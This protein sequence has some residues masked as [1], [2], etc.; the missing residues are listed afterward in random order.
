[1]KKKIIRYVYF[2]LFS[3]F[4][5][6][7]M[8]AE[9]SENMQTGNGIAEE[10]KIIRVGYY[11]DSESFQS[12]SGDNT[13]K[14]GY[15]Y[16]YYQ[17]IAKYTGWTYEYV[18]GSWSE[19]YEKL[20]NGE[21]DIM[22]GISKIEGRESQMLFSDYAMGKESYYIYALAGSNIIPHDAA[23]LDGARI[24]VKSNSHMHQ[25]LTEFT[26]SKGID[27][28][29]IPYAGLPERLTALE[30]NELDCIVTVENGMTPDLL[31]VY[32]LGSSDFYFAVSKDRPDILAELNTAQS[33]IM[34]IFPYYVLQLQNQYFGQNTISQELTLK[35]QEWL[36]SHQELKVGYLT[37]YMPY[38]GS[39]KDYG[40]LT[41][42]LPEL[43][44][45]F[46]EYTGSQFTPI[47]FD[48]YE[49]MLQALGNGELDMI[50]PTFQD[51]WYS[52]HQ[53][54]TQTVSVITTRMTV[55]Y[56]GDY[57][58]G[59]YDRIA[60]SDGSPLQP[61]YLTINYPDAEQASYDNWSE[62]LAA[63]QSGEVGCMLINSNL[64]YRYLS[65][66]EE[67]ADLHVAEL[68]DTIGF[69]FAVRRGNSILYSILNKGLNNIDATSINDAVI[70]NSYVEPE[71]TFRQFLFNN[72]GLVFTIV[73]VFV[74]LLILFFLLYW[75]RIKRERRILEEN[76]EK[77]KKYIADKEEKFNIIG[78]L[79]RIYAHTYYIN[80]KDNVYQLI[81][82]MDLKKDNLRY[83]DTSKSRVHSLIDMS[84]KE[85]DRERLQSFLDL[86]TLSDRMESVD[87]ISME[88]ETENRGWFRGN[89]IS[90]ERNPQGRLQYVIYAIQEINDEKSAQLQAQMALK[91]A[92]EA[93]NR[94]NHA[95]SDF[96]ARMSHDIRTPMN[97]IIGMTAIATTHIDEKGRVEDCLKKI[98]ASGKHL[99][100][101]IN[102]VLDMSKIESGRLE[103]SEEE[104]NIED[105]ID[106]ML[107]VIQPQVD[108][109]KHTLRVSVGD[110]EHEEVIGDSLHIQ[111]VFINILSNSVKYT[112][113]G[114]ILSLTVTE[115]PV[116]KP[117]IGCYEF[118]FE[119]N[120][121]G[122][123]KEFMEHIFEPFSRENETSSNKVQGTGLGLSIVANI[124]RMMG[125]DIKVE[126]VQGEGSKFTVT[127]F[128]KLQD[129][130]DVSFEDSV[131]IPVLVVDDQQDACE[132]TC[133]LLKELGIKSEWVLSG[134]EALEKLQAS[135][136]A[137]HPY[138]A[139][140]LDW[141]MPD[142]DGVATAKAIRD[143]AGDSIPIIILSSYDWP[144]IEI[145]ARAA[146][147]NAFLSKPLL[148]S[149][150]THLFKRLVNASENIN[151]LDQIGPDA[152]SGK[153]ILLAEDNEIN[154]EIAREIFERTG[155]TVDHVWDGREALSRLTEM[156]PGYYDM[157][158]MD[159]QMPIM[160]GH[161]A[162]RAI[163]NTNREDLKKIPIIAMTANAF[164]EDVRAALD[165]GMN[166]H[167]AKPVDLKQIIEVLQ[168]WLGH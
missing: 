37:D 120:G 61:F 130:R 107:T 148:K 44:E 43:L 165:A 147:V 160:G 155:L 128:L 69:C 35:E 93:A 85:I 108:D 55:V 29:I 66:H 113:Q 49:V 63:I 145:D 76:F 92:Y 36:D 163:R 131:K 110:L 48:N 79:S 121:I 157:I 143:T 159:V 17:E 151:P 47:P 144:E 119:D 99:L 33:E 167:V 94:A 98:S 139:V 70:R 133:H 125:G 67:F 50:F 5:T 140:M 21:V 57:Q 138:F 18:Y 158:F 156:E 39:G 149:R 31:P 89:F 95:K 168:K 118:V 24:G 2:I 10:K 137:D 8:T 96:L 53:N 75:R 77:E 73:L 122:M 81:T 60:V 112:P 161:E 13:R 88:Y 114:G 30:E 164:A 117:K 26:A 124:V 105:L 16:E 142:M 87:T 19:I 106:N 74:L 3:F 72:I 135:H 9:A 116:N 150:L 141:K 101:L 134:Q 15:A 86:D 82:D 97:A 162:T 65:E 25:L 84:V 28:T 104:F 103:L 146:G 166:Q 123:S 1:M 45:K 22:A 58:N 32:E 136:T 78:S 115:K 40:E 154:A 71:Y 41:G 27:C 90:V 14:S 6:T 100:T 56:K 111:Q 52:E 126:S 152:F 51:L 38:C 7:G 23:S 127:L 102:E 62:C 42:I 80:L 4:L 83:V 64:V 109:R 129:E 20:L 11:E 153:R 46:S 68:E 59:I 12:G 54:Y 91:D 132:S 34:S